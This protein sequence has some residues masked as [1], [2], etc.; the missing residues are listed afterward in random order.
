MFE[1]GMK[2]WAQGIAIRSIREQEELIVQLL[3][4]EPSS[5]QFSLGDQ[6]EVGDLVGELAEWPSDSHYLPH[7]HIG[8]GEGTLEAVSN[9]PG[10]ASPILTFEYS[11][12]PLRYF[13]DVRDDVP[14]ELVPS[15]SGAPFVFHR[16]AP[17]EAGEW[18]RIEGAPDL[19]ALTGDFDIEVAVRD[20]VTPDGGFALAPFRMRFEISRIDRFSPNIEVRR[21]EFDGRRS[22]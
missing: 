3:H 18:A 10:I 15:D 4:L 8:I 12:N 13:P 21:V 1:Q 19:N 9:G 14:P 7:L 6:I 22:C 11:A 2:S 17:D 5:I 16:V 20:F